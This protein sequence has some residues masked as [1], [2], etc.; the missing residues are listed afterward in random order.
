MGG[1]GDESDLKGSVADSNGINQSSRPTTTKSVGSS[2]R[3]DGKR[4]RLKQPRQPLYN[5]GGVPLKRDPAI[6]SIIES[7]KFSIIDNP[8][9]RLAQITSQAPRVSQ[10]TNPSER[11]SST[12]DL[13][14]EI[15]DTVLTSQSETKLPVSTTSALDS[16]GWDDGLNGDFDKGLFEF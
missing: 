14:N 2:L 5:F 10:R 6:E 9:T 15:K 16:E 8:Y 4:V 1:T 13:E 12:I 7:R 11:P 3:S